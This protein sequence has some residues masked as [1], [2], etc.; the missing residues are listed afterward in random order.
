[1]GTGTERL[2]MSN[3]QWTVL[4]IV[5][6]IALIIIGAQGGKFPFA[7][8]LKAVLQDMFSAPSGFTS[9]NNGANKGSKG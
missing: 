7:E 4:V 3:A 5:G 2:K 8:R 6:L 9:S 1:M